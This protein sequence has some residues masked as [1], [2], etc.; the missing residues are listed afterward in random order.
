MP[1]ILAVA[2]LWGTVHAGPCTF[3]APAAG[4][5]ELTV[6]DIVYNNVSTAATCNA[7]IWEPEA[8]YDANNG[9]GTYAAAFAACARGAADERTCMEMQDC[10]YERGEAACP[11]ATDPM[12]LEGSLELE[13]IPDGITSIDLGDIRR[14]DGTLTIKSGCDDGSACTEALAAIHLPSGVDIYGLNIYG[15]PYLT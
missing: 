4:Q 15:H 2:A 1:R 14:F 5:I 7:D 12:I 9:N 3:G 8:D 13:G 11:A 10:R 6:D